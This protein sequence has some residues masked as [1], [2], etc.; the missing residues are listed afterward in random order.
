MII[1]VEK[2]KIFQH[3]CMELRADDIPFDFGLK[4]IKTLVYLAKNYWYKKI[5]YVT[6]KTSEK[7]SAVI[8]I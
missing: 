5:K 4:L 1:L 2:A 7:H 6:I 8:H 3:F